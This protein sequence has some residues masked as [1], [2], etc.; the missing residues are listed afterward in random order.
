M[1][2]FAPSGIC[3][4]LKE[5]GKL[6]AR[7]DRFEQSATAL[8][9]S[10]NTVVPRVLFAT[11]AGADPHQPGPRSNHG[12]YSVIIKSNLK[13]DLPILTPAGAA[14]QGQHNRE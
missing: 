14:L 13:I 4:G 9:S 8:G 2:Q 6:M 12:R 3:E 11:K 1:V 5:A 7:P 10:L